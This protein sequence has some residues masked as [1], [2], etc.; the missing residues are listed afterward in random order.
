MH[1]TSEQETATDT[2]APSSLLIYERSEEGYVA[3]YSPD[4]VD[5]VADSALAYV[6][7]IELPHP[8]AEPAAFRWLA[9]NDDAYD[10]L[11]DMIGPDGAEQLRD[12]TRK[13]RFGDGEGY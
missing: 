7:R 1:A 12:D 5:Q 10:T 6:D 13:Y 3:A 4:G 2:D 9:N 8:M 11:E